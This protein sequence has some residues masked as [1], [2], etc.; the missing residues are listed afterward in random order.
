MTREE[1]QK[2]IKE[3]VYAGK[4]YLDIKRDLGRFGLSEEENRKLLMKADDYI[5]DYQLAE[6]AR[7]NYLLQILMGTLFFVFGIVVTYIN[8]AAA[9]EKF[10]VWFGAI[11]GGAWLAINGYKKYKLPVSDLID[12]PDK[13]KPRKFDRF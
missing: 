12:K 1:I 4:D 3:Q 8:Y 9:G 5:I 11:I 6:Q 10:Y 13:K 7:S 2:I